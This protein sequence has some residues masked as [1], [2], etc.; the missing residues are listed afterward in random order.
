MEYF[1]S[2]DLITPVYHI[3]NGQTY[4]YMVMTNAPFDTIDIYA[5]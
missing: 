1:F 5:N 2:Q 4:A 3:S